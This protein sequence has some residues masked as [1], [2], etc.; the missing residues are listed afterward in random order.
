MAHQISQPQQLHMIVKMA[1]IGED[2]YV[3]NCVFYSGM[4]DIIQILEE[5]QISINMDMLLTVPD[6]PLSWTGQLL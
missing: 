4:A 1:C 5:H 3:P 2:H 6:R